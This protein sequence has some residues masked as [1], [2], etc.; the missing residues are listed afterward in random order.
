MKTFSTSTQ[1]L[2][3]I[4]FF[5]RIFRLGFFRNLDVRTAWKTTVLYR[6]LN[7]EPALRER[8]YKFDL[9]LWNRKTNEKYGFSKWKSYWKQKNIIQTNSISWYKNMWNWFFSRKAFFTA[10]SK[11]YRWCDSR[12]SSLITTGNCVPK[13]TD[14]QQFSLLFIS[15]TLVLQRLINWKIKTKGKQSVKFR[16]V[17]IYWICGIL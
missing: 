5:W 12:M 14:W 13:T 11:D 6:Q 9:S 10:R 17:I 2:L 3:Q 4:W 16:K 7:Y 15:S 1:I 8:W